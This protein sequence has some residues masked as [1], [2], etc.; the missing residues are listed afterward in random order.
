[1]EL[2][3]GKLRINAGY[4]L[5]VGLPNYSSKDRSAGVSL[6]YD[7][8]DGAD[9]EA[10]VD[11]ALRLQA[12]LD[13]E[14][15]LVVGSSLDVEF[16][17]DGQ[18]ILPDAPKAE[19]KSTSKYPAKKA[20]TATRSTSGSRG[21]KFT[22][23][24]FTVE[25]EEGVFQVKDQRELIRTGKFSEKSPSFKLVDGEINGSDGVWRNLKGGGI[26]PVYQAIAEQIE[27]A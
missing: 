25:L 12:R 8:P 27:A 20:S 3:N 21:G 7:L 9:I 22:D 16:G 14:V 15:K 24:V 11:E 4:S 18:P 5:K 2:T 1:M 26:N 6:E 10:V 23:E 13:T 17:D 19:V